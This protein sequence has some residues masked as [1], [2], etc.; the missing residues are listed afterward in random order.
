M[1]KKIIKF[2]L[3]IPLIYLIIGFINFLGFDDMNLLLGFSSP[4][5]W[6]AEQHWFV[7]I[8]THPSNIFFLSFLISLLIWFFVGWII[9]S[10]VQKNK[11]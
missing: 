3:F 1:T 4:F 5:M 10:L 9:D 2:K 6:I 11:K 8:F 7:V